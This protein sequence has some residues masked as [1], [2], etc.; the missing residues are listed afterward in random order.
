MGVAQPGRAVA[1]ARL[2]VMAFFVGAGFTAGTVASRM[3]S[4]RDDLGVTPAQ[5]GTVLLVGALGGLVSL[6]FAG[7]LVA[8][9]GPLTLIRTATLVMTVGIVG[10][11]LA[12]AFAFPSMYAT[13]LFLAL[14][15]F[16]LI[17]AVANSNAATIE[18]LLD[19]PVMSQFHAAFSIAML[20][21]I[22]TGAAIAGLGI[23]VSTHFAIVGVALGAAYLA[24][25]GPS[26]PEDPRAGDP[27]Q[28]DTPRRTGLFISLQLAARERRTLLLGLLLLA[29]FSTESASGNWI[30]IALVDDFAVTESVAGL[31]YA[32]VVLAQSAT[33]LF[34]VSALARIGRV[35]MLRTSAVLILSGTLVFALAPW[36]WAAPVALLAWGAGTAFSFPV[37]L[38]A[39]ADVRTD[40]TARVAA[41]S[42]FGTTGGLIVPQLIGLFAEVVTV[43]LALLAVVGLAAIAIFALAPAARPPLSAPR[44]SASLER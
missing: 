41:V 29:A 13:G 26:I 19:R 16:E 12:T 22:G 20:A 43:R 25:S 1:R 42:V 14:A 7:G 33:R 44:P 21:G 24:A 32:G 38:S 4:V 37:A 30:P 18:R 23:A 6:I 5:L 35:A 9:L 34:G 40:A 36:P 31:M 15:T 17:I 11:A 8:R 2:G 10:L 27:A 28:P 3:P 39:A